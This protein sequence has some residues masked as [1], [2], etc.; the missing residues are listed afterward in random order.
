MAPHRARP[1]TR[2]IHENGIEQAALPRLQIKRSENGVEVARI[3]GQ[4]AHT[5]IQTRSSQALAIERA[6]VLAELNG[7]MV[8]R[9]A[10]TVGLGRDDK[11]FRTATSSDLEQRTIS[12]RTARHRLSVGIRHH[13]I[14]ALKR[15]ACD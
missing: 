14:G 15:P 12:D 2:C 13:G 5:A 4:H 8:A 10:G 3:A 1:G 6:L 7:N 11:R 9:N